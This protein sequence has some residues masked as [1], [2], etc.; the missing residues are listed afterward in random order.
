[1]K[2]RDAVSELEKMYP[3]SLRE[4]WDF[5]GLVLGD[6]ERECRKIFFALDPTID[7]AVEAA[8]WGADLMV[9]HHPL[10]FRAVH[11]IP[12]T[13]PHGRSAAILLRAGCAL[14]AGHTNVDAAPRGTN[15]ALCARL[16][17]SDLSPI[18]PEG[19]FY[20]CWECGEKITAS[21]NFCPKCGCDV[22]VDVEDDSP[23]QQEGR[24]CTKCGNRLQSGAKFCGKCGH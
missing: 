11:L 4:E 5:P 22:S 2:V 19:F 12:S 24:F 23:C 1:M 14:W 7:T 6:L 20:H 9:T 21:T 13:D 17:I 3:L 15:E 16:G 10:F 18:E 8:E